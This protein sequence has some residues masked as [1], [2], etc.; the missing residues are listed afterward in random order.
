MIATLIIL[1]LIVIF[2]AFFIGFNIQNFCDLWF[3]TTYEHVPV[4]L[5]IFIAFAAGVVIALLIVLIAKLRTPSKT[6]EVVD[7]KTEK[8]KNK[9]LKEKIK[10]LEDKKT[11]GFK[12][13]KQ[14]KTDSSVTSTTTEFSKTEETK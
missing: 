5:L 2:L 13:N 14:N 3:F 11:F 4:V 6:E 1:I 9:E 8:A 12:K 10:N 7:R